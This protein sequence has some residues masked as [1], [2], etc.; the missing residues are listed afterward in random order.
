MHCAIQLRIC[1]RHK[2]GC[3]AKRIEAG[4]HDWSGVGAVEIAVLLAQRPRSVQPARFRYG[5][6]R[7]CYGVAQF[8][9][10]R[11]HAWIWR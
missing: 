10:E 8:G 7:L 3:I 11:N 2:Q 5:V 4:A 1:S 6:E 9:G